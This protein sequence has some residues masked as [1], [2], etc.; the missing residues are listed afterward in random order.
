M[1][2]FTET[3]KWRDAWFRKLSPRSKLAFLYVVDNCDAAGVWDPDSD[4]ANFT[5]GEVVDWDVVFSDMGE[6]VEKL[7]DGKW[8]LTRFVEFQCGELVPECRPHAKIISLLKS[9]GILKRKGIQRVSKGD[10]TIQEEDNTGKEEE[11]ITPEQIYAAYPRK[12]ARQ[13][14]IN[15]IEKAIDIPIDPA[16]ILASTKAY[17]SAVATWPDE[18]RKYVPH[19]A[20]WYNRGSYDD[21]PGIWNRG[22]GAAMAHGDRRIPDNLKGAGPASL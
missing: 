15:A 10:K 7:K 17:A 1:K 6:R 9:H 13:A 18:E 19:A 16:R 2:R 5:I 22:N 4:L 14:A 12:E 21:D 8:H 11:R 3:D 20:T